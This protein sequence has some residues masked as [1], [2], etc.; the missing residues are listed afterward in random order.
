MPEDFIFDDRDFALAD[1]NE[2]RKIWAEKYLEMGPAKQDAEHFALYRTCLSALIEKLTNEAGLDPMRIIQAAALQS[3]VAERWG[4]FSKTFS[5]QPEDLRNLDQHHLALANGLEC[6]RVP[7]EQEFSKVIAFAAATVPLRSCLTEKE[8]KIAPTTERTPVLERFLWED[9]EGGFESR[10][11]TLFDVANDQGR[12]FTLKS[13][14]EYLRQSGYSFVAADSASA[15]SGSILGVAMAQA[16][17]VI[18]NGHYHHPAALLEPEDACGMIRLLGGCPQRP[19]S[20]VPLPTLVGL[21]K[22]LLV[23]KG[24]N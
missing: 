1:Q 20:P 9:G 7:Y 6:V 4:S 11:L 5:T 21:A 22:G 17:T 3:A 12:V 13:E 8:G 10:T 24:T 15:N 2:T 19:P 16:R 23:C 18:S 14:L